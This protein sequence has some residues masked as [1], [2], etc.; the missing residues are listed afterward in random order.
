[1]HTVATSNSVNHAHCAKKL[2]V[3]HQNR[4]DEQSDCMFVQLAV[5]LVACHRYVVSLKREAKN[6]W[7]GSKC[8]KGRQ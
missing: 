6:W 3:Q 5:S 8:T 7:M 1:M 2:L 4:A